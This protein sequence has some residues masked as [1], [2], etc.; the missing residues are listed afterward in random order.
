MKDR[1]R[2][3]EDGWKGKRMIERKRLKE[4]VIKLDKGKEITNKKR[5]KERHVL[6]CKRKRK[7]NRIARSR[8]DE[9]K[10]CREKNIAR[11][12]K[13]DEEK[14]RTNIVL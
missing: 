4:R 5:K 6:L 7:K 13:I 10:S 2:E 14:T 8:Y 9:I 1:K 11:N 3:G 12:R